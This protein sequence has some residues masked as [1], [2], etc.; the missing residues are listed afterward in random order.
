MSLRNCAP[1]VQAGTGLTP[2]SASNLSS[3]FIGHVAKAIPMGLDAPGA[4]Q[5]EIN[6]MGAG[7]SRHNNV[8]PAFPHGGGFEFSAPM[9]DD[10]SRREPLFQ[11]SLVALCGFPRRRA[12]GGL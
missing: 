3:C 9:P 4:G 10:L 7:K 5:L 6:P 2:R 11:G 8:V 1:V 12:E